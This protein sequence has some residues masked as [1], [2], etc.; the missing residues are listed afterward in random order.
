MLEGCDGA[1]KTTLAAAL[2][3][4]HGYAIV[5]ATLSPQGTDLFAKYRA[6]LA[7][8]GPLVLD[9]SFVSELV[10]GPLERGRSR[11][12]YG[13]AARLA[14]VAA[15]RGGILAHLT[16]NPEQILARLRE[17][18]GKVPSLPHVSALITAYS[19]VCATLAD[20]IPIIT[21]DTTAA[22]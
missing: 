10:Y 3:A 14:A 4:R 20:H 12:T 15:A 1:G 18:G 7:R 17:R 6:A 8:H 9:R 21:I 5:H 11:L 13:Q 22:P 19:E 16:G 2:E